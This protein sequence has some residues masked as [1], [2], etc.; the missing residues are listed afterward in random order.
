MAPV[1]YLVGIVV[2][3]GFGVMLVFSLVLCVG[4]MPFLSSSLA[5]ATASGDCRL[6]LL[7]E[8]HGGPS[9]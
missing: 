9:Q 8:V 7:R 4:F 6:F 3:I 1:L 5:S 2:L